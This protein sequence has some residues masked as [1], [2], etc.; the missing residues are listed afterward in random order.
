MG[1]G[2]AEPVRGRQVGKRA[3]GMVGRD[4]WVLRSL[5]RKSM[6]GNEGD[7]RAAG[8]GGGRQGAR[9]WKAIR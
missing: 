4:G 9:G 7:C 6:V 3:G 8:S 1:W 2:A 5:Q